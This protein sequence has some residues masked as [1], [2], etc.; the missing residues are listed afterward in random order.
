MLA[1]L[2]LSTLPAHAADSPDEYASVHTV[3]IVSEMGNDVKAK[4]DGITRFGHDD[5]AL[6]LNWDIDAYFVEKISASLKGRFTI[7]ASPLDSR[8]L[9]DTG[10]FGHGPSPDA[11]KSVPEAQKVDA[12]IVVYP[13]P[14][15]DGTIPPAILRDEG[16]FGLAHTS[17][18]VTYQVTI[19]DGHTGQRIN[20]GSGKFP[21]R[22]NLTGY[23]PPMV[24]CD[25]A[26]WSPT[27]DKVTDA[28]QAM[29]KTEMS[30]LVD[31]SVPYALAAAKL[32]TEDSAGQT[33]QSGTPL[34]AFCH[35]F[36]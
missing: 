13:L 12:Y 11:V 9:E 14:L 17:L 20:Y 33:A 24:A 1:L 2:L 23:A 4:Y 25:E 3:A 8:Q 31:Q 6:H 32:I 18:Y 5:Y 19:I 10:L 22:H 15:V 7:V 30:A 36:P 21:S 27:A 26:L 35:P 34:A 28:Q 16:L 29:L